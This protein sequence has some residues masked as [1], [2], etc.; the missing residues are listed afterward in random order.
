M[1]KV[2]ICGLR[3][4]EDIEI[5]NTYLPDYV[6][7][8]INYPKSFRSVNVLQVKE[9]VRE[10]D[11]SIQAVGVFVDESIEN[12]IECIKETGID[13]VQLHGHE[14][15]DYIKILQQYVPVIKAFVIQDERD[16]D[17]ALKSPADYILLDQGNGSGKTFDWSLVPKIERPFFLAGGITLDNVEKT[18]GLKPYGINVSSSVETERVKDKEKVKLMIEKG[19]MV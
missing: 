2:K 14:S 3:R 15:Y 18:K 6:G 13:L 19:K 10:L 17:I 4:H 11:P 12:V 7:F 9:M 16:I 5:V 1:A 8:I